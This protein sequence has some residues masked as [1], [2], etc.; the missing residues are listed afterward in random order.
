MAV[1]SW[2]E[3]ASGR[4]DTWIVRFH[5]FICATYALAACV[6]AFFG[7]TFFLVVMGNKE[8]VEALKKVDGISNNDILGAAVT[9]ALTVAFAVTVLV[10]AARRDRLKGSSALAAAERRFF[11]RTGRKFRSASVE[12]E[13]ES[14]RNQIVRETYQQVMEQQ[15]RGL[16]CPN[17]KGQGP[18][19]RKST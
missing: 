18:E 14:W 7:I 17:C 16:L 2:R 9:S 11:A 5:R 6:L 1:R 13:M 8:M 12:R 10:S 19:N 3:D 4:I 15:A